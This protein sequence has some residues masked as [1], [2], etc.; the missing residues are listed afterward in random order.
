[1]TTRTKIVM[2]MMT[3]LK[4]VVAGLNVE[5]TSVY[6]VDC[7]RVCSQPTQLQSLSAIYHTLGITPALKQPLAL[8]VTLQCVAKPPSF[9]L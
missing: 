2:S 8:T 6:W 9:S 5:L 4:I 3:G 1:M 7:P